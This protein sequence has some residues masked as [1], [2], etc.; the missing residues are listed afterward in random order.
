MSNLENKLVVRGGPRSPMRYCV[1][2]GSELRGLPRD[3]FIR[4][5]CMNATGALFCNPT[6]RIDYP[7]L[8]HLEQMTLSLHLPR[9]LPLQL[10]SIKFA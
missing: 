10:E 6:C 4:G 2:C 1:A 9:A 5:P 8:H 3:H 7:L